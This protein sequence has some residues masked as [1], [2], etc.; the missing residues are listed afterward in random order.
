MTH[1]SPPPLPPTTR[2]VN[3]AA[4]LPF[5]AA[6]AELPWLAIIVI[7]TLSR[8]GEFNP[9]QAQTHRLD[10]IA[11]I[12]VAFGLAAGIFVFS[13]GGAQRLFDRIFL[14]IGSIICLSFLA[15]FGWELLH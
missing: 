3:I 13:R 7:A 14:V 6:V 1:H 15:G 11:M 2:K 10:L 5:L 9:D 8:T 12:P 4:F